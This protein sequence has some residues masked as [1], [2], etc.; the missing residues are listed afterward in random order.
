MAFPLSFVPAQSWHER[1]RSFGAP[2]SQGRRKHAGCDL[3]APVDTSV[4]AVADGTVKRFAPFYRGTYALVVDHGGFV[5]RYGEIKKAIAEDLAVGARVR[6][7]QK[8][9]L[10][11]KLSGLRIAM[12]H[13]EMYSG[14]GRGRLTDPSRPPFMRR[15]DLMDP[16]GQ[17]D[18]WARE[19][20]PA[21]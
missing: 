15:S 16:T 10:V 12:V 2:R 17:L 14:R 7:G 18:A 13:F 3:Y 6:K 5:V 11:G 9:G 20:L 21:G 1:P 8:I 19:P 4:F